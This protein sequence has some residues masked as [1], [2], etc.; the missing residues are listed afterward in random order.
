VD[1][2][3]S[4]FAG[5]AF[6]HFEAMLADLPVALGE[7]IPDFHNMELRL[8]QLVDAVRED[9]AG[10]LHADAHGS[11]EL[12]AILSEI[13]ADGERMCRAEQLHRE[14]KLPK[15]VCH[16][17]T[18]VNNML[19]DENGD[20]LCVI[21]L[22]TV[23]PGLAAYDFGDAVRFAASTAAEDE[24]DTARIALDPQKFRAF[25]EGFI[26]KTGGSLTEAEIGS[27]V[28]GAIAVT[29]EL[30]SRFLADYLTGDKYFKVNYEGHNLVRTRAQLALAKEMITKRVE[31]EQIVRGIAENV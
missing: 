21:D 24:P 8:R 5:E 2:T 10:R 12:R 20:V 7:T 31:M 22:D 4:E 1:P 30:A 3:Y 18:K 28:Q 16:C 19:F 26:G 6:G 23:M 9:K 15:R 25:S 13:D 29:I 14:G 11:G 27:M 17:D